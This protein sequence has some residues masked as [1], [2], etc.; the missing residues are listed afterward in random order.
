M[1][2]PR[3][4]IL[5]PSLSASAIEGFTNDVMLFAQAYEFMRDELEIPDIEISIVLADDFVD[6]VNRRTHPAHQAAVPFTLDR[7]GS[8]VIGK[9]LPQSEDGSAVTIVFNSLGWSG[10]LSVERGTA[11]RIVAHELAHPLR[12]RVERVSGALEGVIFPSVTATELARSTARVVIG[13]YQ[14]DRLAD[15]LLS[16]L[17]RVTINGES[18]PY[19]SWTFEGN[20][21]LEGL[22]DALGSVYPAWPDTVDEY[23]NWQL[24]LGT[25][26]RRVAMSI[27]QTLTLI[28]HVQAMADEAQAGLDVLEH[29]AIGEL[30]AVR[31]Y[32]SDTFSPFLA[33]LRDVPLMPTIE[34]ALDVERRVVRIGAKVT[35]EIWRRLGLHPEEQEGSRDWGLRVT[36]PLR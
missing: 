29:E 16:R 18:Q 8:I 11:A 17:L 13:E 22:A 6:E 24:D 4:E 14:A 36:E 28:V 21:Y 32:L 25:M 15:T 5:A 26:F 3:I 7:V 27:D 31:L 33:E 9:N 30:P 19:S 34:Q 12:E 2:A 23:R 1:T 35:S 10:D 20:G